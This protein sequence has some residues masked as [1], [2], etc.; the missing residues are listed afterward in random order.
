MILI[1]F[2]KEVI[3]KLIVVFYM[4]FINWIIKNY[5]IVILFIVAI[6][7]LIIKINIRIKENNEVLINSKTEDIKTNLIKP[8]IISQP[9]EV[10]KQTL[11]NNK[12]KEEIIKM[13]PEERYTFIGNLSR[14]EAEELDMMADYNFSSSLPYKDQ[15]FVI[16]KFDYESKKLTVKPLMED[17]NRIKKEVDSWLFWSAGNNPRKIDIIWNE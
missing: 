14:D 2:K 12:T 9:T 6:L 7:I 4:K 5:L 13:D 10:I 1:Y 3:K 11:Y 17:K 8:S 16:E 15:N